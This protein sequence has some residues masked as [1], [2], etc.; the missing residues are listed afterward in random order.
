MISPLKNL[1]RGS[2]FRTLRFLFRLIPISEPLRDR[3]RLRFSK[4]FPTLVPH[5]P[6]GR[7]GTAL[8]GRRP[9]RRSAGRAIGYVDANV[10][11]PQIVA[12]PARLIAFYL[13]Q[14]H[15]IPENDAWWGT[16]FTE[17]HNVTRALPQFEGHAQPR[18]PADLGYYDLRD[19]RVMRAQA[20]LAK[21][22]G[23]EGFCAYFYWFAG[24]TLLE[25]PISQWLN[26]A[27]IDLPL[28]LCW[29]NESWTRSWDGRP[30]DT[31]IAQSDS[32]DD[33]LGFIAHIARYLRDPRYIRI[34]GKPLLLVYRPDLLR[35]PRKTSAA[36]RKWCIDR[37]IGE[38]VLAYVQGFERPD[39]QDL[40]FDV[41]VE[42]P[43]NLATPQD[44]T[45]RQL[46]L[47]P[48]YRGNALDWRELAADAMQRPLPAYRCFP[49]VNCGWDNAP[50]Q[51]GQGRSYLHASPRRYRDW[52]QHTIE[53]RLAN[54]PAPDRVVFI[55]AWNEWAE[56]AVLEPD[57]RLGHAWLHATRDA[58]NRAA[59]RDR[60]A[61]PEQR[62]CVVIHAWYADVFDDLLGT[63]QATGIDWRYVVTTS[64]EK[65]DAIRAILARHGIAAEIEVADNRGRDIL[66]FLRVA[67]RLLDDGQ[68]VVLK[69]HTKQSP[70]RTDGDQW[71]GQLVA[72]LASAGN[73]EHALAAF[74]ASPQLGMLAAAGHLQPMSLFWGDNE[75]NVNYLTARLGLAPIDREHATFAAGSMF[76]V[77]LEALRPILDAHLDEWEFEDEAAQLDGTIAHAVERLFAV[78]IRHG[79]F[80]V[81]ASTHGEKHRAPPYRF[82]DRG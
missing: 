79:G 1:L 3:F 80:D 30:G 77:R 15:R 50:R 67:N 21:T 78:A 28:C 46:L 20:A 23:I 60:R 18:L 26:D 75:D 10:A 72:A 4:R 25:A 16:G 58:V 52:L 73:A 81:V 22:A 48:D 35:N 24:K 32:D 68:D 76:W 47:N 5:T 14:F 13:P 82:A 49:A 29:A 41:A 74:A 53:H 7:V 11:T 65:S 9:R 44:L 17:W 34:D 36:W 56:G 64:H 33:A 70:H 55:N 12:A 61:A 38:I 43:P 6:R 19:A 51:P 45:S 66:P 71:R 40:G 39:P 54:R 42:F 27:D 59:G 37:G 31:L 62:P 57:T 2:A 63:L 8:L 69:L